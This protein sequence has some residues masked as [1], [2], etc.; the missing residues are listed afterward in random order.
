MDSVTAA[1]ANNFQI[2]DAITYKNDE[3]TIF[4]KTVTGRGVSVEAERFEGSLAVPTYDFMGR[5][6]GEEITHPRFVVSLG[7]SELE[8]I[9]TER[10]RHAVYRC[11]MFDNGISMKSVR[12]RRDELEAGLW[13]V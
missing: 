13:T 9:M 10:Y 5:K 2:G 4:E 7:T 11:P 6:N 1:L 3:Y 12:D 8:G